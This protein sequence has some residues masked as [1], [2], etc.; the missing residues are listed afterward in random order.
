MKRK[1]E[2]RLY[3]QVGMRVCVCVCVLCLCLCV[4]NASVACI[5]TFLRKIKSN[6]KK[7]KVNQRQDWNISGLN[8]LCVFVIQRAKNSIT[9]YCLKLYIHCQQC[10]HINSKSTF[11]QVSLSRSLCVSHTLVRHFKLFIYS[12]PRAVLEQ[13]GLHRLD[14]RQE[15]HIVRRP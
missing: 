2:A 11:I 7:R 4:R 14:R 13:N 9:G 15:E 8:R 5:Y 1:R 12:L 10:L 6:K 3:S